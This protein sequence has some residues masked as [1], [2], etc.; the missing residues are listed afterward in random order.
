M[1][2]LTVGRERDNQAIAALAVRA[3]PG[4]LRRQVFVSVANESASLVPRRLELLADGIV[5]TAR[6]LALD[7]LTRHDVVIDELPAD[8]RVVEARLTTATSASGMPVLDHLALD[9][10]AWA[11][12]PDQRVRNVLL[13]GDGSLFLRN[14][15]ALLPDVELYGVTEQEWEA[16]TAR[17]G[18]WDLAVLEGVV[19]DPLPQAPILAFAPPTSSALGEVSG[20]L[21]APGVGTP[22]PDEPLLRD[23]DLSRFHVGRAQRMVTPAWARTVVPGPA[24]APLIYSGTRDGQPTTVFAFRL[25]D[26]DLPLQVAWPILLGNVSAELLGRDA[27]A[28]APLRPGSVVE[29]P[30][31]QGVSGVRVTLPDGSVREVVPSA[32]GSGV[33]TFV[34]TWQ[35]GVYRAD[36]VMVDSASP[37]QPSAWF[38]VDLFEPGESSIQPGDGGAIAALG[39]TS[40]T[41]ASAGTARDEW[42]VPL[43]LLLLVVLATEWLLYERDGARRIAQGIRSR[44]GRAPRTPATSR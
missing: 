34:D 40:G 9:D 17:E 43:V 42:W 16:G 20:T 1:A 14:A 7:G 31:G 29:L 44:L 8:A 22:S 23:V 2:V 33:A 39:G 3:D 26:S 37:V 38:A 21:A 25:E 36:P 13:I 10:R 4:G 30:L 12:V 41:S 35:L 18:T 27:S 28:T 19:P 32:A 11:V 6:D 15:L 24:D 5:F